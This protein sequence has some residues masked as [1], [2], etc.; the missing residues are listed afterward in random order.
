MPWTP[1]NNNFDYAPVIDNLFTYFAANQ[2]DALDWANGGSGLTDFAEFY[3]NATGRVTSNFPFMLFVDAES[4][5][6]YE[7]QLLAEFQFTL[8]YAIT[9]AD[10]D[11]MILDAWKYDT[12]IKSMITEIDVRTELF[13]GSKTP[14]VGHVTRMRPLFDVIGQ[15]KNSKNWVQRSAL[16]VTYFL[17]S[18]GR[19]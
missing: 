7:D 16:E 8:E 1:K 5:E 6:R 4:D 15:G 19:N 14:V 2:T 18:Q 13:A 17:T 9:G 10:K 11:Q 12:A 3:N